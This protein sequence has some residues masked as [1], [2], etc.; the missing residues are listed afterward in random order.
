MR[1]FTADKDV[2]GKLAIA[3]NFAEFEV[4]YNSLA[5]EIKI[6]APPADQTRPDQTRLIAPLFFFQIYSIVPS[7]TSLSLGSNTMDSLRF[8]GDYYLRL[9]LEEDSR[10]EREGTAYSAPGIG[11]TTSATG[12]IS[13]SAAGTAAASGDS[14]AAGAPA[15]LSESTERKDSTASGGAALATGTGAGPGSGGSGAPVARVSEII[16]SAEFFNDLYHRFLLTP[17]QHLRMLCLQA[18]AIVYGRHYSDIGPFNDTKYIVMMLER[19]RSF[20]FLSV[21]SS[22]RHVL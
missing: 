10:E 12:A 16:R 15:A 9:L 3:W 18:M 8:A 19:V 13:T 2:S 5:D 7:Y 4:A 1:L 6:G 17:K 14:A 21:P 20:S 22:S 11:G